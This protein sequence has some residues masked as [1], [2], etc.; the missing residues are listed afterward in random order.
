MNLISTCIA[1]RMRGKSWRGAL[2][3]KI[4]FG[5]IKFQGKVYI[6]TL[7]VCSRTTLQCIIRVHMGGGDSIGRMARLRQLGGCWF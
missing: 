4:V 5:P 3:K 7:P 2:S 6:E 1:H